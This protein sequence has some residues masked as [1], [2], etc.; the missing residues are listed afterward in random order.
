M[1]FFSLESEFF[2]LSIV[3]RTAVGLCM[4]GSTLPGCT[5]KNARKKVS[6]SISFCHSCFSFPASLLYLCIFTFL[7]AWDY[8]HQ[9]PAEKLGEFS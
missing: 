6:F 1:M 3:L 9:L 4:P 2:C 7:H 8:S 5:S